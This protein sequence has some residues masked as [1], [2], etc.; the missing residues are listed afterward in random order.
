MRALAA[1]AAITLAICVAGWAV[2]TWLFDSMDPPD[3]TEPY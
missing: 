2:F 1:T 3:E